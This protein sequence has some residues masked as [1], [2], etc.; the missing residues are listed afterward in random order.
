M[1][2]FNVMS[3]CHHF[4]HIQLFLDIIYNIMDE[5]TNSEPIN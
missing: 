5:M 1:S 2:E 4:K 3:N